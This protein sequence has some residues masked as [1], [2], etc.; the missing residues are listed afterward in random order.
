M[1]IASAFQVV[2]AVLNAYLDLVLGVREQA[3]AVVHNVQAHLTHIERLELVFT[4]H[5]RAFLLFRIS[6]D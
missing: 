2:L 4:D 3:V 1:A 5:G 6:E